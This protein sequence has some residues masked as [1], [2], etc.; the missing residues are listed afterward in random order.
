M[1]VR[2][3]GN[4]GRLLGGGDGYWRHMPQ[5]DRKGRGSAGDGATC[6]NPGRRVIGKGIQRARCGQPFA[7]LEGA[8]PH[9]A[10]GVG[11]L[12]GGTGVGPQGKERGGDSGVVA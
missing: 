4:D 12:V 7:C 9:S 11:G 1:S 3:S 6:D 5:G 10:A 2:G 8:F